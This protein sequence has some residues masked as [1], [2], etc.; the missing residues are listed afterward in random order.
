MASKNFTAKF[1]VDVS[2]LKKG[3]S[4]ATKQ[5]KLANATFKAQTAGLDDWTKSADGLAAKLD[6]LDEV[7]KNQKTILSNYREQLARV[8]EAQQKNSELAEQHRQKLR[9]LAEQGVSKSSEEYKKYKT[10]LQQA[11]AELKRNDTAVDK[12]KLSILNQEAA[13]GK[14]EKEIKN[15]KNQVDKLGDESKETA[16]QTDNLGDETEEAGKKAEKAGN[17]GFTVLR[18]ALADLVSKGIQK[19]AE[20]LKQLAENVIEQY[21]VYEQLAGGVEK[22]FSESSDIVKKYAT[23]AYK[24]AGLSANEYMENVT[25]FSAALIKSLA[26]DTEKAAKYADTAIGDMADNANVFGSD[27][28]SIMN[29]YQ[30]FAKGQY[31]LLDNLKLGYGGTK[32]EMERLLKDAEAISGVKYNIDSFA[33]I[34]QAI[35]VIQTEMGITGTTAKEAASTIS[36]SL[37]TAKSAINNLWAG[38]GDSNADVK[39]LVNDVADS[40]ANVAKNI[41]PVFE[42]VLDALPSVAEKAMDIISGILPDAITKMGVMLPQFA[43]MGF[44]TI[45][46]FVDAIVD[47]ASDDANWTRIFS[48]IAAVLNT[49]ESKIVEG[50]PKLIE[51]LPTV[52]KNIASFIINNARIFTRAFSTIIKALSKTLPPLFS[53]L[54]KDVLPEV[55]PALIDSVNETFPVLWDALSEV[56]DQL[57]IAI[58]TALPDLIDLIADDLPNLLWSIVYALTSI[59][60]R[61]T[62][63]IIK[64][65]AEG[66]AANFPELLEV[67]LRFAPDLIMAMSKAMLDNLPLIIDTSL[68]MGD[69]VIKSLIKAGKDFVSNWDI[70]KN[71]GEKFGKM[72]DDALDSGRNFLDKLKNVFSP[73]G[74]FF[75]NMLNKIIGGINTIIDGLNGVSFNIPDWVPIVGG[76]RFGGFGLG[77][78]PTLQEGGILPR[79]KWGLLEGNGAEAVVPLDQNKTWIAAVAADMVEALSMKQGA[80][81]GGG[82]NYASSKIN[83]FTQIIN[84]P[85]QPTRLELYR[86]TKNLLS[87]A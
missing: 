71:I 72:W 32:T 77:R 7:L 58:I 69:E 39:K 75:K 87:N 20:G 17:G 53:S 79:G 49:I 74:D 18:G 42:N 40:F 44:N 19:A 9:E 31:T 6:E 26:G 67:F 48:A 47:F 29:A 86:Q 37:A 83:N 57:A 36:G 46:S 50:A 73:L 51:K 61:F 52:F 85:K 22:L 41:F 16:K 68:E 56:G 21:S 38:L 66:F 62:L 80:I 10:A 28:E 8:R 13:V 2:Q 33:D 15:Y 64:I 3:I 59:S 76:K 1:S 27:M 54:F 24:T 84:A 34:I 70:F 81:M 30:S 55:I 63:S 45:A 23:D 60:Q 25:G 65:L 35:H 11:E 82:G 4:D 78:I 14:T 43:E 5:I 12:L